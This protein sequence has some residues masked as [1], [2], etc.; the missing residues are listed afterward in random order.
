MNKMIMSVGLLMFSITAMANDEQYQHCF[1]DTDESEICQAYLTGMAKG[2][3]IN[4]SP[5]KLAQLEDEAQNN[6]LSRALE[7]RV[8]E[9]YRKTIS[10][11]EESL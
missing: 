10:S 6:F 4:S 8:G 3:E 2:L 7:Q 5:A 11:S 1:T 9:R